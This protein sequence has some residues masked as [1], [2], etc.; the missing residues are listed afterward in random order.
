M[1][2][3]KRILAA[4]LTAALLLTGLCGCSSNHAETV[5]LDKDHPVNID[6]W[7]YYNGAQKNAFDELVSEFNTTVGRDIGIVV[8]AYSQGNIAQL[9][10]NVL[11]SANNK[12]GTEPVPNIVAAYADSA[13]QFDQMGLVV[14]LE[15]YLTE[16]EIEEYIPSYIEEGRLG[17]GQELKIFPTAKATEVL[18]INKT[19][20]DKF[21]AKTGYSLDKL[22]TVE[23]LI[24]VA[25]SYYVW[26]GGKAF[27]GRDAMANYIII[28]CKQLGSEIFSVDSE[29]KVTFQVDDDIM[30]RLWQCYYVPY[31]KGWFASYGK[32]RSDDA[33]VGD[34]LALVGST[35]T[36]TYFPKEV[37]VDDTNSYPIE[38]AVMPAPIFKDG[39]ICAV[40]QG[41][42]MVVTKKTAKEEYASTVFLKWFTEAQRN[43]E[44]AIEAGYLPVKKEASKAEGINKALDSATNTEFS[45]TMRQTLSVAVKMTEDYQLYTNRAFEGGAQ[46]RDV[47]EYSMSDKAMEDAAKIQELM[48]AGTDYSTAVAMF[49]TEENF[50]EW[51]TQFKQELA[52]TQEGK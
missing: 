25:E 8:E 39:E 49:D 4:A 52:A 31:I 10:E 27:Y 20:W 47:L 1:K 34:I 40:Q 45:V 11:D 17:K 19:D 38:A 13:Y 23:G 29:G 32:F 9:V 22:S 12:V 24:E 28:G 6:I 37:I 35:T 50:Q 43:T 33:K 5:K 42:G 51:L 2:K 41:A 18:M 46:A 44:F 15:K 14:S 21:A 30:R 26:S 7:H 48:D 16:D 36:A 3:S